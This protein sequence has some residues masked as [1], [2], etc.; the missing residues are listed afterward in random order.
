MNIQN[1][2]QMTF[3]F[4]YPVSV[5][6]LPVK[7][8]KVHICAD[9]QECAHLAKNHDLLEVKFC[10]GEFQI[11]PWKKRGV[12]I[13]GL[14]R[15]NIIQSCVVT[16]EPLENNIH[17]NIEVV[18]VPEGSNLLKPEMLE[19]TGELFLDAEGPDAPEI[20]YGDKIDIGAIVEEFFELSIDRYP[21]KENISMNILENSEDIE[22]K[23]SPFSILKEWR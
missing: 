6:S 4:S 9:Q 11:L 23:S 19:D 7:G 20:F 14:L 5:S 15:A 21:R 8:I 2:S 22:E 3:A 10:E 12:Y 16:L 18:F 1:V 13:K 17:E